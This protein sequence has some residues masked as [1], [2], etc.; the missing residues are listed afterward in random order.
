MQLNVK[1]KKTINIIANSMVRFLQKTN[2][3]KLTVKINIT[4][5]PQAEK[6][7]K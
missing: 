6:R 4:E 2:N 3:V 7:N 5:Q 1:I